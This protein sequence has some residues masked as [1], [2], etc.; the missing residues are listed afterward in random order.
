MS[1]PN[2]RPLTR[3]IM[4]FSDRLHNALKAEAEANTAPMAILVRQI[5]TE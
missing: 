1:N 3:L 4:R 5:R 2:K